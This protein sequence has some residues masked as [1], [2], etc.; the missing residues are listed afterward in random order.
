MDTETHK[1]IVEIKKDIREL[2]SVQDVEIQHNR[3]KFIDL[4][5]ETLDND[6]RTAKV[7][8]A[9]DGFKSR[10]DLQE[11]TDMPQRTC[12]R[13]VDKLVS[14]E[15]ITPLEETKNGSPV[16][17]HSRWFKKLRLEE[18]VRSKFNLKENN[19]VTS[20]SESNQSS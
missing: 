10:K 19:N 18:Y 4:L 2:R 14:K 1:E 13:K 9:I 7:L 16:Y 17:Q 5:N 12:W 8:L 6:V 20:N 15:I 11:F 3:Q